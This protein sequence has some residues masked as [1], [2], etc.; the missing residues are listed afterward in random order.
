MPGLSL[1]AGYWN[2]PQ[3][4]EAAFDD[5]GWFITGDRVSVLPDGTI[6]FAERAKDVLKVGGE[7]VSAAEIERAVLEVTGV[8]EC[9]VVGKP[10]AAYGEVAVAFITLAAGTRDTAAEDIGERIIEH[11]RGVLARFKVPR[12]VIVLDEL[13]RVTIGKIG[14]G[15]LR[16]R[17]AEGQ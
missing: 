5:H 10:D 2:D 4:T 1:F 17:L 6:R 8:R 15:A 3:A 9:A 16:K 11:C 14:K 12:E 13:P 7:G